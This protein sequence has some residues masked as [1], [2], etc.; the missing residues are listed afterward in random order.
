MFSS[1]FGVCV[2][3]T[4]FS[5]LSSVSSY[6]SFPG[7]PS[8]FSQHIIAVSFSSVSAVCLS[9]SGLFLLSNL[10]TVCFSFCPDF[11]VLCF[12]H[13]CGVHWLWSDFHYTGQASFPSISAWTHLSVCGLVHFRAWVRLLQRSLD[14]KNS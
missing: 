2:S 14:A 13:H 10:A 12:L 4:G 9:F 1:S 11:F 3:L 6:G 7:E 8:K 5:S